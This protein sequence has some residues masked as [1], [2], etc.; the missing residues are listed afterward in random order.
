MHVIYLLE[1]HDAVATG[2]YTV[3]LGQQ[4]MSLCGLAEDSVSM[5]LTVF[6]RLLKRHGLDASSIGR[7]DVGS[8]SNP[9]RAKSIRS[10]LLGLF[11]DQYASIAGSDCVQACY[12]GTAALLNAVAWLSS[13]LGRGR[14]FAV[15]IASDVA[16]YA[17]GPAR[18]TGGAAAVAILLGNDARS[19]IKFDLSTLGHAG[20]HVYDFYKPHPGSEYPCVDGPLSIEAYLQAINSAF[21]NFKNDSVEVDLKTGFL[22][23]SPY[24]R[25]GVKAIKKLGFHD[26]HLAGVEACLGLSRVVG[27]S[28]CASLYVNLMNL[29]MNIWSGEEFK[30]V[31]MCSY[32]SG[33]MASVFRLLLNCEV[34]RKQAWL[35]GA[36]EGLKSDLNDRKC[37]DPREFEELLLERER[38]FAYPANWKCSSRDFESVREGAFYL[39]QI[40]SQLRR[41]YQRKGPVEK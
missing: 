16:V 28:Y 38:Q 34:I 21:S 33:A 7:L 24:S 40:D 19:G 6:D 10:H 15:V 32:G 22:F 29:L 1:L 4:S 3:G 17:P 13:P 26:T 20:G 5:A 36:I 12:G 11:G 9:D 27:N 14:G 23:H 25:I 30:A 31:V 8:E 41:N 18:A 37:V 39:S 2:K 35:S